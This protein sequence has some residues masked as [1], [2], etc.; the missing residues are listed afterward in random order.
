MG[1]ATRVSRSGALEPRIAFR[2]RRSPAQARSRGTVAAILEAA[3]RVFATRGYAATTTNHIAECAGVSIG[4]LYEYFAGKDAILVALAEAHL[5]EVQRVL[6]EAMSGLPDAPGDLEATVRTVVCAA[7]KVHA[8]DP[9]LH[10]V[11][12]EESSRSPRLRSLM[13]ALQR[14]AMQ[15]W[16]RQLRAQPALAARDPA[17][18][19]AVVFEVIESIAHRVVIYGDR[20]ISL[21]RYVEE[22]VALVLGY[23]RSPR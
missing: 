16:E 9:D 14:N 17:L 6:R 1:R 20:S 4:S 18:A 2:P 10:R 22:I 15:W 3:T 7:V 21:E 19:A 23:L 11:L 8:V 13:A 12:S 5:E